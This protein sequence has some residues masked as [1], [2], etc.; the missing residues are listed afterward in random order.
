MRCAAALLP[1]F[2]AGCASGQTTSDAGPIEAPC[3]VTDCF[4][5]RDVRDFDVIDRN[6]VVVYVGRQRC[7]FVVELQD[8]TCDVTFSP[9]IE[10]FQTALGRSDRL[11]PLQTGRVCASTRG[12]VLYAGIP[13]PALLQQQDVFESRAGARPSTGFPR[14]DPFEGSFPVDPS[15]DDVCRVSDIRSITDDQ[16]VELLAEV[17]APPPPV[18]EGELEV[19]TPEEEEAGEPAD[20]SPEGAVNEETTPADPAQ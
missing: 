18:G 1:L 9:A 2:V 20:G 19:E 10:F 8:V 6:T 11:T 13:A 14:N 12:L 5:D 4:F 7:P 17:N 15:S 3:R 16:L